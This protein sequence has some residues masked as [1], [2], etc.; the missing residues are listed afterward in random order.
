M[1]PGE[2]HA[3]VYMGNR[4]LE[5]ALFECI[6]A[7]SSRFDALH[8]ELYR[9]IEPESKIRYR[10]KVLIPFAY[11]LHIRSCSPLIGHHGE[12]IAIQQHPVPGFQRRRYELLHMLPAV[13]QEAVYFLVHAKPRAGCRS[14]SHAHAPFAPRRL[15]TSAYSEASLLKICSQQADVGG[16]AGA[17]YAFKDKQ[18]ATRWRGGWLIH[19]SQPTI[20][21]FLR[22]GKNL[23]IY[24]AGANMRAAFISSKK[25]TAYAQ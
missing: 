9:Y 18:P 10:S 17:V 16:F 3:C 22:Q 1:Q 11:L 6:A 15:K 7:L 4:F 14:C 25:T 12:V 2:L 24:G 23:A 21:R 8:R 5:G 13:L 19:R 20:A